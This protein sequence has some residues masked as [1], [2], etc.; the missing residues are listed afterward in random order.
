V[1]NFRR[2][3][4]LLIVASS[5]ICTGICISAPA[6]APTTA[7]II[8]DGEQGLP[9]ESIQKRGSKAEQFIKLHEQFLKRAHDGP[10]D[11]LFLGDSIT[12]GWNTRG[13][14]IWDKYY[15][16]YHAANFGLSGDRTQHVIW[17]I[18]NGELDGIKPKVVVLMIG[19]NN[20][21]RDSPDAIA[22]GVEK[23]V[24]IVCTKLPETK[25][26]LLGVFPRMKGYE[27]QGVK[28]APINARISKLDDAKMIRYLDIGDKFLDA[29]GKVP[30]DIMP[31]GLHPNDKGY[32]IWADAMQPLLSEVMK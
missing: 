29:D 26:L 15:A 14:E 17:R 8:D 32:Q 24:Q 23:I 21:G 18:E 10:I 27:K 28:I 22:A 12:A 6:S 19:T 20:T 30:S 7:P 4:S 3:I 9:T 25:I 5:C 31:D 16:P 2:V 13:R 1:L 11:L